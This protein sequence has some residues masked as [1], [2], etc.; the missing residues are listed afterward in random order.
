MDGFLC[1]ASMAT[2]RPL[3]PDGPIL[4]G[5][6]FLN[7]SKE[8]FCAVVRRQIIKDKVSRKYFL[9]S[10]VLEVKLTDKPFGIKKNR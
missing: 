3:I 6:K 7:W 9:I 5:F 1:T 4:R 2:I 8:T 10:A